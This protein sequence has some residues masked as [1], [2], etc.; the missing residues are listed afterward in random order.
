MQ[1]LHWQCAGRV[2]KS[3]RNEIICVE[4]EKAVDQ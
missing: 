2:A 4:M 1:V 3:K